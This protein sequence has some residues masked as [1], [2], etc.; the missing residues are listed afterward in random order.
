MFSGLTG[1]HAIIIVG[2]IVLIFGATKL[3]A[4][5]R[6]VAQSVKVLQTELKSNPGEG[7]APDTSTAAEAAPSRIDPRP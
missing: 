6:G 7:G 3:P 5:A 1:L 4:L 2:V